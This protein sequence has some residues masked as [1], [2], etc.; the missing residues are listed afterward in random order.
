MGLEEGM[1]ITPI[2]TM[3]ETPEA[4]MKR[5]IVAPLACFNEAQIGRPEDY[6][7]LA[8]LASHPDTGEILGGLWGE[9]MF[10]HLHVDVL[11]VPEALRGMGVGRRMMGQ[12]EDEAIRRGC[13]GAWLDTFSFQARGFYERLGYT[14]FGTIE[15]YPPGHSRLFLKKPLGMQIRGLR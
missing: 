15:D 1:A 2:I 6:R 7:C 10:S 12:A 14:V 5:A 11:F 13:C 3:T 8:I 4:H 9:T